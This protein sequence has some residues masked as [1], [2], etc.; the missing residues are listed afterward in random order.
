MEVGMLAT[1]FF[2]IIWLMGFLL[3]FSGLEKS[4]QLENGVLTVDREKRL[5]LGVGL[6]A[7]IGISVVLGF[8]YIISS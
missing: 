4:Q 3:I 6:A 8:I 7:Y 1:S 5:A 2:L